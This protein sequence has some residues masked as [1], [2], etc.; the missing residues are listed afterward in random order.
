MRWS[1][2][3]PHFQYVVHKRKR[4]AALYCCLGNTNLNKITD[5]WNGFVQQF[6]KGLLVLPVESEIYESIME[7]LRFEQEETFSGF[8]NLHKLP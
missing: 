8:L 3:K 5:Y 1:C 7:A 2:L 4:L 6:S